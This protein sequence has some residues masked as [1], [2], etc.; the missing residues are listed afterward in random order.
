LCGAILPCVRLIGTDGRFSNRCDDV[1]CRRASHPRALQTSY[2]HSQRRDHA[3]DAQPN[4]N[5]FVFWGARVS[6]RTEQKATR[7]GPKSVRPRGCPW[8]GSTELSSEACPA[9][10]VSDNSLHGRIRSCLRAGRESHFRSF[11]W[12]KMIICFS[13][14][15]RRIED[16][17]KAVYPLLCRFLD[18]GMTTPST[19]CGGRRPKSAKARSRGK[20]GTGGAAGAMGI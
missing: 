6:R 2:V 16:W 7:G 14:A 5:I 10:S 18:A 12:S 11:L 9:I 3:V 17:T 13:M 1:S 20:F 15:D 19:P 4:N 8:G